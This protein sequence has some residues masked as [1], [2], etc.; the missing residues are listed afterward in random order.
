MYYWQCVKLLIILTLELQE[1]LE[2]FEA[3]DLPLSPNSLYEFRKKDEKRI[4]NAQRKI[5]V[6]A[7]MARRKQ[8]GKKKSKGAATKTSYLSGEFG[9][10]K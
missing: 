10:S 9:L 6:Q 8:R 1:V 2:F 7:R 3:I 5:S 4:K